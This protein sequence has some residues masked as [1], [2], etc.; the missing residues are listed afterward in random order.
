[1]KAPSLTIAVLVA[2]AAPNLASAQDSANAQATSSSAAVGGG[3]ASASAAPSTSS[4]NIST[5]ANR[6]L[7]QSGEVTF[8]NTPDVFSAPPAPTAPCIVTYGAGGSGPGLGLSLSGGIRDDRCSALEIRRLAGDNAT[9]AA[10]A[11][12][13]LERELDSL[14]ASQA[15]RNEMNDRKGKRG[16]PG[17]GY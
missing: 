13:Y 11:E 16:K 10:K 2:L 15:K 12:A 5:P 9:L 1:M 6:T 17:F 7:H 14:L 8:R 3:N 4:V